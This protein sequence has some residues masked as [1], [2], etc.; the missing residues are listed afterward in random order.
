[1]RIRGLC[2][3]ASLLFVTP[4]TNG[5]EKSLPVEGSMLVGGKTYPLKYVVA[6]ESVESDEKL[7]SV[8][9]SD[10]RIPVAEIKKELAEH[11]GND[12]T[13]LLSQPYVRVVFK[14]GRPMYAMGAANGGNFGV[15]GSAVA[16]ESRLKD[17]I[18]SGEVR[19]EKNEEGPFQRAF[20]FKFQTAFGLDSTPKPSASPAT[21]VKA[22][23]SGVFIGNGRKANLAFVSARPGEPFAD[24][25]SIALLFTEKDHTKD[26]KAEFN[27]SFGRYGSALILSMHEDGSIFG[28]QVAHAAHTKG[29]FSSTGRIRTDEF[30]ADDVHVSG[31]ITTDGEQDAFGQKWEVE[32][33]FA[34]PFSRPVV[35]PATESPMKPGPTGAMPT[36]PQGKPVAAAPAKGK[37]AATA[38]LSVADLPFLKNASDVEYKKIVQMLNFKS[39]TGVAG[40]AAQMQKELSA[41]GWQVDGAELVN[42]NSTI[43]RRKS[44]DAK[45][46]IF[47]KPSGK[48]SEVRVVSEGLDWSKLNE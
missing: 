2:L 1:M 43:L 33:T 8:L 19:L 9:A 12:R 45:L 7:V 24:K 31:K 32:M 4:T 29:A 18:A 42:P 39:S 28:C 48:G 41:A 23:A 46:T 21:P 38:S 17:G 5:A 36:N 22:M 35:K 30:E 20:E 10:R 25:P 11:E 3:L 40:L 44:G 27:A 6:Y 37:P 16:G 26:P 15:S 13:L 47:I 34:A 14:D